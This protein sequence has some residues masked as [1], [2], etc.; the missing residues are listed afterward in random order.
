MADRD[1]F[2]VENEVSEIS[3]QAPFTMVFAAELVDSRLNAA[4]KILL[5]WLRFRCGTKANTWV[6]WHVIAEDLGEGVSTIRRRASKL[7]KLGWISCSSRG[8]SKTTS[9][10]LVRPSSQYTNKLMSP[11]LYSLIRKD[12]DKDDVEALRSIPLS[13]ERSDEI[14]NAEQD[15][16]RSGLSAHTARDRAVIPL[17]SERSEVD[18]REI[19]VKEADQA[20][21]GRLESPSGPP[22]VDGKPGIGISSSGDQYNLKTGEVIAFDVNRKSSG[23]DDPDAARRAA[24]IAVLSE[25]TVSGLQKGK[26]KMATKR[27]R[28]EEKERSGR[29]EE[30]RRRKKLSREEHRSL[31]RKLEIH[32]RR[33]FGDYFPNVPDGGRWKPPQYVQAETLLEK[34][35]DDI[36]LIKTAWDY[37][38]ENWDDLKKEVKTTVGHPSIGWLLGLHTRVFPYV[39]K[40]TS[41]REDVESQQPKDKF[42][43]D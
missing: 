28:Q 4:E 36:D 34:Y 5:F 43:W 26:K 13:S 29:L 19:D 37:A 22:A 15:P 35:D 30:E 25:K 42:G 17:G 16:L 3:G 40:V 41:K 33:V 18:E 38:C 7:K 23:E 31:A 24:A 2:E 21:S 27:A 6:S 10:V 1:V 11:Q 12:R 32:C 9:K 14:D 20:P 8:Y 39:V